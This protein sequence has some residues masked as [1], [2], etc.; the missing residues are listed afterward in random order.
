MCEQ[1]ESHAQLIVF[2]GATHEPLDWY[3]PRLYRRT[4]FRFLER[5]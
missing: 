5:Q 3:D 1:I 2:E 4:L